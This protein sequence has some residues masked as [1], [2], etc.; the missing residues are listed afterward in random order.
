MTDNHK[1]PAFAA[2]DEYLRQGDGDRAQKAAH[3]QTAIGLQAVDG[4]ST[5]D[6]LH[7]TARRHIEGEI[8][9]DKAGELLRTYYQSKIQRDSDDARR[10]EAEGQSAMIVAENDS[11]CNNCTLNCTLD[12]LALLKVIE[13]NPRATQKEIAA[14]I[15]KSERTVKTMTVSLSRRGIII[16]KN[17]KRNGY[18]ERK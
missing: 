15:G 4:L 18:W 2:F 8:D 3:W 11:K 17:G 1:T 16:R 12:E 7:Q 6:Y 13:N 10:R 9:I 14:S 5:S